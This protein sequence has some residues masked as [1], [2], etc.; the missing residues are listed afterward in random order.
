MHLALYVL[1]FAIMLSG[2]L[3]STADSRGIDVFEWFEVPGFGSLFE[4]QEDIAGLFHQYA[5][6]SLIGLVILHAAA[7]IKHHFIDKDNTLKRMI[8]KTE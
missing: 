1:L 4:N 7:A 3:I 6:Y 5:A 8:R 2:Y